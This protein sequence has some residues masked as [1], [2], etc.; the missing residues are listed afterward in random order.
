MGLEQLFLDANGISEPE[1][2]A[3]M[4]LEERLLSGPLWPC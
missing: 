3:C 2:L 4:G 1:F